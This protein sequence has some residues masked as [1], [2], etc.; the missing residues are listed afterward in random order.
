MQEAGS[1]LKYYMNKPRIMLLRFFQS[2]VDGI[3]VNK[4]AKH[5][6]FCLVVK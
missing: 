4:E 6:E 3:C 1:I 5:V 2:Y